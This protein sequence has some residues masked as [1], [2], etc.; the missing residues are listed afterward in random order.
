MHG[1]GFLSGQ[2]GICLPTAVKE[3][4]GPCRVADGEKIDVSVTLRVARAA[5][6]RA[7]PGEADSAGTATRGYVARRPTHMMPGY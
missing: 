2:A 4:H 6:R 1:H 5:K 7:G 3:A